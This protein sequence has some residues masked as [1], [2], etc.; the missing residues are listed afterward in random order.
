MEQKIIKNKMDFFRLLTN[1]SF[2]IIT[3]VSEDGTIIF[4]SNATKKILGYENGERNGEY[5]FDFVHDDDLEIV[6]KKFLE[7]VDEP[8]G[9]R[10]VEFRFKHQNGEW[11]WLES[12]GQNFVDNPLIGGIIVNSRD[13]TESKIKEE[14]IKENE[15]KLQQILDSTIEA[16]VVHDIQTG[17]I[18]DC[19][20]AT[21]VMYGYDSK[22]EMLELSIKD[23][24]AEEEGFDQNKILK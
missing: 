16:I 20:N 14:K 12:N 8:Q 6:Q 9:I 11:I 5:V 2:E 3:V 22:K 18:I 13:I 23:V 24:S 10:S 1:N 21:V 17:K 19:N 15:K 7:L 4:E